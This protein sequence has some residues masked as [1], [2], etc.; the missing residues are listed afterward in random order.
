MPPT[1]LQAATSFTGL[2]MTK[3]KQKEVNCL[4]TELV[5]SNS[6]AVNTSDQIWSYRVSSEYHVR[7]SHLVPTLMSPQPSTLLCQQVRR[8][9]LRIP[10]L[11]NQPPTQ[12]QA[13]KAKPWHHD[14][15]SVLQVS[16]LPT[17]QTFCLTEGPWVSYL[18]LNCHISSLSPLP[19]PIHLV[20]LS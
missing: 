1:T 19:Q 16:S 15:H 6:W 3:L 8:G 18:P 12:A 7:Y 17:G 10:W 2:L 5:N 11:R 4:V 9:R 14:S 13:L 20:P